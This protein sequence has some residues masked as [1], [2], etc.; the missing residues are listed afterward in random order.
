MYSVPYAVTMELIFTTRLFGTGFLHPNF[1]VFSEYKG[2]IIEIIVIIIT[3]L[4]GCF[5][6]FVF[7]FLDILVLK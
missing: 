4:I 2:L 6:Y 3:Y 7:K 5:S 1:P